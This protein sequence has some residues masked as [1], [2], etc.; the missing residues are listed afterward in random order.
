MMRPRTVRNFRKAAAAG[1]GVLALGLFRLNL[2]L[3]VV[4]LVVFAGSV[5]FLNSRGSSG[6]AVRRLGRRSAW[7]DGT[8][9][10]R[11]LLTVAS[12]H[13]VRKKARQI[14]PEARTADIRDIATPLGRVGSRRVGPQVWSAHEDVTARFG[15]PRVGK[16]GE[17]ACRIIDAPGAVVT[18]S[19][20][21]DLYELTHGLRGRKGPIYIFNPSGMAGLPSTVTFD[22][23]T[24][25]ERPTVAQHRAQDLIAGAQPPGDHHRGGGDQRGFW[26]LQ[27]ARVLATLLHAAALDPGGSGM[28]DVFGWLSD[29]DAADRAV[30]LLQ[31]SPARSVA[32]D[33]LQFLGT[34]INTRTSI[35][36]TIATALGWM[37]SDS[38]LAAAGMATGAGVT[39]TP[40]GVSVPDRA[41]LDVGR[42]IHEG[43]TIYLLG[44]DDGQDAPLVTAF[45]AQLA[46]SARAIANMQPGGRLARPLTFALDEAVLICP[47]PLP[48]WTADMG[49]RHITIHFAAQSPAQL[50]DRWGHSGAAAL[51]NNCA[52]ILLF[53]G[54]RDINDLRAC[55]ELLGERDEPVAN[56]DKD[57]HFGGASTRRIPVVSAAQLSQL[58]DGQ[59]MLVRRGTKPFLV[60]VQ[61]AWERVDVK[62]QLRSQTAG[63]NQSDWSEVTEVY[64][65]AGTADCP[66]PDP[67]AAN[68]A[69][70]SAAEW[71]GASSPDLT[72]N[73]ASGVTSDGLTPRVDSEPPPDR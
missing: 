2:N 17:M 60:N 14:N 54:M 27:A 41:G 42:L 71:A 20:R 44:D 51:L 8:A 38:A 69:A 52:S 45:T 10:N 65:T 49:G 6:R 39:V 7:H 56:F 57:H 63:A 22:P 36:T 70:G 31:R 37:M 21:V 3:A 1:F 5:L 62:S 13:A 25:C 35:T 29:P 26:N 32:K 47:V 11:E 46:R 43:G 67:T 73:P 12:A 9:S 34:N 53:G 33:A 72:I 61:M 59:A 50:V 19:T 66:A 55:V 4:G 15:G 64:S 40:A 58:R 30:Q 16:S 18:T 24:G 28:H 68:D 48:R 23:L